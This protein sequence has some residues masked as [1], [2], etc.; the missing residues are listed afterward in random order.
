MIT[1]I[2]VFV[3]TKKADAQF[4]IEYIHLIARLVFFCHYVYYAKQLRGY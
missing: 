4:S 3:W 1:V 2:D